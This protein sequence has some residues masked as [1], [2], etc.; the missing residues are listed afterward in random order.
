MT[1]LSSPGTELPWGV[2]GRGGSGLGLAR[3]SLSPLAFA[4]TSHPDSSLLPLCSQPPLVPSSDEPQTLE[5][6]CPGPPSLQPPCSDS[7]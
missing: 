2:G 7:V 4:G 5:A 1:V 6:C 3:R